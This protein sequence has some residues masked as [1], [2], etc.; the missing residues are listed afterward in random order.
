MNFPDRKLPRLKGYD[1][2]TPGCYFVTICTQG[3]RKLFWEI[4]PQTAP[5]IALSEAGKVVEREIGEI[6]GHYRNVFVDKYT[7]MPNHIHMIVR[8][9]ERINP[10]PTERGCDLSNIVGKFKA[11]VSRNVGKAFMPSGKA[12]IWQTSY[13]DHI[14]RNEKDY[15]RIWTYID[16]NPVSWVNDCFYME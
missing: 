13:H 7:I 1:Y 8:I 4:T 14:I 16:N 12:N 9:T 6:E 10:F 2:S 15:Q 5:G 11:A 3:K